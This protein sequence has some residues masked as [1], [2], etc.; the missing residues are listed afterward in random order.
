MTMFN[1]QLH[2]NIY[3]LAFHSTDPVPMVPLFPFLLQ[4]HMAGCSLCDLFVSGSVV[5][6]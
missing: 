6:V 3:S 4:S 5:Q 1:L 2:R